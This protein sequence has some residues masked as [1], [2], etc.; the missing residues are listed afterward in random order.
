MIKLLPKWSLKT[1]ID[2]P[3]VAY[4]CYHTSGDQS[5]LS[6]DVA[7]FATTGFFSSDFLLKYVNKDYYLL[8]YTALRS[9]TYINTITCFSKCL[10][11]LEI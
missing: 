2:L 9:Y 3:V 5:V 7:L 10:D 6:R 8:C 4:I 1:C 11:F